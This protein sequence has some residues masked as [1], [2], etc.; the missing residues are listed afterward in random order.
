[1]ANAS[2]GF[3]IYGV[4]EYSD[5]SRRHLPEKISPV[6]RTE[7][8]R[9]W[10]DQVIS[11]I[12]PPINNCK[13]IPVDIGKDL[14]DVVYVI[15]IPQGITAH[16]SDDGKYYRRR[17]TITVVLDHYEIVDIMNRNIRPDIDVKFS[18][19]PHV[20]S[21]DLHVYD[22]LIEI[23][24]LGPLVNHFQLDFTF[25]FVGEFSYNDQGTRVVSD[26]NFGSVYSK[27][28]IINSENVLFPNQVVDF[29]TIHRIR[30]R[31]N[32]DIYHTYSDDSPIINWTLYADQMQPKKG[33]VDFQ[34]LNRF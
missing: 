12:K 14:D 20:T 29:S 6:K 22:L 34:T 3:V 23:H 26:P 15:E 32:N 31:V 5:P 25:K 28:V 8:S 17:N 24:N 16:Q 33:L 30:Y 9:E 10:I 11:H 19:Q 4:E 1:M 2:G 18:Y 27:R 21:A 13:I 7:I